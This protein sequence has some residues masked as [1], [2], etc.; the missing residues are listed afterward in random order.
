[1]NWALMYL[2]ISSMHEM[3]LMYLDTSM[4][5]EICLGVSRY[6]ILT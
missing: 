6:Q 4:L 1:M 2:A 3:G 5:Q